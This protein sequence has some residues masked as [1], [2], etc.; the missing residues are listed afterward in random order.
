MV[1]GTKRLLLR[2]FTENDADDLYEYLK[3]PAAHCF[4]CMKL[5]TVAEAR[6]EAKNRAEDGEYTFAIVL[7][8]T[9]KVIGEI[10]AHP[11]RTAP[12][13]ETAVY[14][15]FSPC[16]MLNPAYHGKGYAYEAAHAFFGYLFR[17]KGARRIYAY[18][19]DYNAPSRRLCEKLGMRQEGVF[20]EFVSFVNDE[21]GRPLLENTVQY[22][23]LREEWEKE[24]PKYASQHDSFLS[25]AKARYSVRAF[26]PDPV[27][28]SILNE[29]LEAGRAAPTACNKQP[30][31]I[32]A[33]RSA[34]GLEKLRKCTEC[35]YNAPLALIV[36]YDRNECWKRSTD[37]HSSGDIDASIV[38]THLML[39]AVSLGVGSTWVMW[40][41]PE[42]VKTEF[43][44]PESFEPT[45]ILVMGYPAEDSAPAK[46]HTDKK[47]PGET[48]TFA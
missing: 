28:D 46:M 25:L 38:T 10:D 2:P 5:N 17:L 30:Q 23:V 40:F 47:G 42:A 32:I 19:E 48:V 7:K 31:R 3:Q 9:G 4:A 21:N 11:E 12:D 6:E 41:I 24:Q 36:G 16:W 34:E 35:H 20:R 1:I 37:G 44:T 18:A 26:R 8:E 45:A 39:A 14:D 15:T 43:G 29:I 22:A 33:V 13:D 27:P